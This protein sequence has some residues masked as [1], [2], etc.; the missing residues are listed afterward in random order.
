MAIFPHLVQESNALFDGVILDVDEAERFPA[1]K[2][3]KCSLAI[4]AVRNGRVVQLAVDRSVQCI[5]WDILAHIRVLSQCLSIALA[6]VF[7]LEKQMLM[8]K[9]LRRRIVVLSMFD[10]LLFHFLTSSTHQTDTYHRLSVHTK[11]E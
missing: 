11:P 8:M 3:F 9:I 7:F 4:Y 2:L 6:P 10:F 1:T 5:S